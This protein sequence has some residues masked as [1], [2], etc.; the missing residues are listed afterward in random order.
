MGNRFLVPSTTPGQQ[1]GMTLLSTTTLSGATVTIASIP[2]NYVDLKIIIENARPATDD[3]NGYMRLNEDTNTRYASNSS[4]QA[5][6]ISFSSSTID[7]ATSI[8]DNTVAQGLSIITIPNYSNTSTWKIVDRSVLGNSSTT[9]TN[10]NWYKRFSFYNQVSAITSITLYP[11]S[12][13]WTSGTVKIY[14]VK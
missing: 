12:G 7:L 4:F 1:G 14:G 6:N 8:N 9:T 10:F 13:N 3:A 11:S 5:E 2:S